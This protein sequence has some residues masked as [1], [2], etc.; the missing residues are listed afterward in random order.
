MSY[1]PKQML[2][3]FNFFFLNALG[4]YVSLIIHQMW[5]DSG[6]HMVTRNFILSRIYKIKYIF[7]L[8]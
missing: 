3:E 6:M 2:K 5:G 7:K 8:L 1:M 4:N